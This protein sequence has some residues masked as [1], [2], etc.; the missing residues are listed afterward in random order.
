MDEDSLPLIDRS[1]EISA[2]RRHRLQ[3]DEAKG[4]VDVPV[5][6]RDAL[7][8]VFATWRYPLHFIDFETARPALPF[9]KGHPPYQLLLFQFSHHVL[10]S[11]GRLRHA[12]QCLV[13]E[14]GTAPSVAVVRA[15]RDALA[16]DDGTV[17]HWWSHERT[18]LA[19]IARQLGDS[20]EP[21]REVLLGLIDTLVGSDAAPGRLADLGRLVL[22]TAF[23]PG[24][25]GRSSIKAVLPVVLARSALLQRRYGAPVYG[26]AAMPS[27]NFPAGWVWLQDVGGSVRDPYD[28][29][30][31][32]FV[33]AALQRA[34]AQGEAEDIEEGRFI[35]NGGAAMVAY[36]ELQRPDLEAAA[37]A[38]L[39]AQLLRYCELDTLAMVMVY[40]A[41]C[42]WVGR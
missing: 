3:R 37:R 13:A 2:S 27:L 40:E 9:H 4:L 25:S 14:P 33:D 29:L 35:Q 20:A 30:D 41:L 34:V 38:R 12:H 6:E 8:D 28:L 1:R 26:T 16:A 5:L 18:V 21:D 39:Q 23:F 31:P 36:G 24:T 11:D 10:E 22:K 7:R 19:E 32:L 15:L 17:V 42:D